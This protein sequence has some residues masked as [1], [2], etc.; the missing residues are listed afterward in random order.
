MSIFRPFGPRSVARLVWSASLTPL[1]VGLIVFS[2]VFVAFG[3]TLYVAAIQPVLSLE[4]E[5]VKPFLSWDNASSSQTVKN[6]IQQEDGIPDEAIASIMSF[7]EDEANSSPGYSITFPLFSA[8]DDIM[9][10]GAPENGGSEGGSGSQTPSD[11]VSPG[12][13]GGDISGPPSVTEPD[14]PGI[15]VEEEAAI[16]ARLVAAYADLGS[17]AQKV[18]NEYS[19]FYANHN[20]PDDAYKTQLTNQAIANMNEVRRVWLS[21]T[22]NG[23]FSVPAESK[24]AGKYADIEAC[25]KDLDLGA[26]TLAGTWTRIAFGAPYENYMQL[27]NNQLENGQLKF[28][29]DFEQ[30]Y[31]GARP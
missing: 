28:F 21:H 14:A 8:F 18:A 2:L 26:S 27:I 5:E 6:E 12:S 3:S 4:T 9:N 7:A 10:S 23:A 13:P 31:P 15:S 1:A 24:W 30:R 25:Y 17:L 19:L 22:D 20:N 11:P 29:T 16:H